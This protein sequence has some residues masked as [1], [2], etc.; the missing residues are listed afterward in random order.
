MEEEFVDI[1]SPKSPKTPKL[2]EEVQEMTLQSSLNDSE[3]H[4]ESVI[5]EI[6]EQVEVEDP[7]N[8]PELDE[9]KELLKKIIESAPAGQVQKVSSICKELFTNL[10]NFI[11]K[12]SKNKMIKDGFISSENKLITEDNSEEIEEKTVKAEDLKDDNIEFGKEDTNEDDNN[13][14]FKKELSDKIEKYLKEFYPEAGKFLIKK[15]KKNEYK[16]HILAQ[17]IK[18][19]AFWSGYWRS[20]WTVEFKEAEGNDETL[21]FSINGNVELTVHYHEEGTV[22]LSTK[23]EIPS[24]V[25]MKSDSFPQAADKIYWK[26]KDSEDA[27]Q[28]ALNEAYQQLAENIFKKLRRQLPVTRTKM[29]WAKFANYNL[30]NELKK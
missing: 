11:E 14:E 1:E 23:K 29:D 28:L 25:N 7:E 30:S 10:P 9:K 12:E 8:D 21:S 17:K 27:I 13:D 6:E 22:Q 4:E 24:R 20:V 19:K 18:S 3:K 26:I 15:I 5:I 16:I 2:S